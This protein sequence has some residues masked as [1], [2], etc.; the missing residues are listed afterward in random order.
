MGG[1]NR[2]KSSLDRLPKALS[3]RWEDA[4]AQ[5]RQ[6]G[7][8]HPPRLLRA[9]EQ[10]GRF[11]RG[12]SLLAGTYVHAVRLPDNVIDLASRRSRR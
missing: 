5:R 7:D 10:S 8:P 2:S 3:E 9:L 6:P 12:W 4:L 1:M 11:D